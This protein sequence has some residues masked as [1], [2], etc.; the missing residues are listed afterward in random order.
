MQ[1]KSST[2]RR[3]AAVSLSPVAS[4]ASVGRSIS[5]FMGAGDGPGLVEHGHADGS[6]ALLSLPP[7]THKLY[8]GFICIALFKALL[9]RTD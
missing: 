6:V 9:V 4:M 8:T 7:P 1:K 2:S 3:C 5:K